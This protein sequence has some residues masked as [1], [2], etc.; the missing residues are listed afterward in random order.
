MSDASSVPTLSQLFYF[1]W[2]TPS[3]P[4]PRLSSPIDDDDTTITFTSAPKDEGGAVITAPFLMG[5]KNSDSY[6]ETIYCP[7]GADGASGLSAT[8]CIRGIDLSGLDYTVNNDSFAA[9]H[10]QDSPVFCN[11]TG[12]I[13]AVIISGLQGDIAS[14]GA[15]FIIGTDAAANTVTISRSTAAGTNLPWLRWNSSGSEVEFSDNGTDWT[16]INDVTT[17]N[18]VDVSATDTTPGYLSAKLVSATGGIDFS[19]LGGGGNETLNLAVERQA[20]WLR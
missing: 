5:V 19:T 15:G 9:S 10:D 8:G 1:Q 3:A 16:A 18:L 7:N 12:V 4:N 2:A 20:H 6:V 17:S 11:V 14:G 13:Q